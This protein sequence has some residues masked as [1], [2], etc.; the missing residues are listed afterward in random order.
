V[1]FRYFFI[2]FSLTFNFF[3]LNPAIKGSETALSVEPFYTF[4]AADS[5]NAMLGFGWF[6]NGFGL[7]D[8]ST[9]CTFDSVFP[10]SGDVYLNDGTLSLSA[11][12]LFR[13][14]T[15]WYT[16]GEILGNNYLVDL[17]S[18]ITGL[19]SVLYEQIFDNTNG[20]CYISWELY[21]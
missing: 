20:L 9:S 1:N 2:F 4:P 17:S 18:S 21:F 14:I 5:D 15:T 13:N 16:S 6:K 11:D 8:G 12:L 10:V 7:E 3:Y 19:G